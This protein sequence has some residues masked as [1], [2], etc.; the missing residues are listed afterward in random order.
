MARQVLQR[1]RG[2]AWSTSAARR[3]KSAVIDR[4]EASLI[5]KFRTFEGR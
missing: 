3:K 4:L 2:V 1:T 5:E